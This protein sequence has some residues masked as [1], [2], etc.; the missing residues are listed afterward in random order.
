MNKVTIIIATVLLVL[1]LTMMGCTNR[2]RPAQAPTSASTPSV[3]QKVTPPSAPGN[4]T[5][6]DV[7]QSIVSIQWLDNSNNEQGFRLCRDNNLIAT[8]PVNAT[9]YQDTGLKPA[10]IYQYEVKAYNQAG[11]SGSSLCTVRTPGPPITVRLDRIGVYD[12]REDWARGEDGEVYIGIIVTDGV[13]IIEKR[14][15]E[16]EG[17]H[18]KLQKNEAVDIGTI[19]FSVNAVGDYIRIAVV[20]YEDDGGQG[21]ML[22]YQALVIAAKA[23]ISG[24]AGTL[25]GMTDFG[26]GNLLAK[27]FGAEDDWLGAYENAWD[28]D[29]NWGI[30]RYTDIVLRDE[31]GV[32]CLRLWFTIESQK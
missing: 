10:T 2:T 25:L 15:P 24:G 31:R 29:N 8:L 16:R 23:Y 20:G 30:G 22:L 19:I 17:Q 11:E 18:Y 27:L 7:S 21:E 3:S 14:F 12:N 1:L 13:T 4:L 26:L 9:T 5:A 28:S 32:D 6:N